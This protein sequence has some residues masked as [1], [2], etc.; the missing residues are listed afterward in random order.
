MKV[1]K[2]L[3]NGK[4]MNKGYWC[5]RKE[6][7]RVTNEIRV[8]LFRDGNDKIPYKCIITD[9]PIPDVVVF[10]DNIGYSLIDVMEMTNVFGLSVI[11][12]GL[13][14]YWCYI[15]SMTQTLHPD[16]K[17]KNYK[18]C[19]NY[20]ID[21]FVP[22]E[23]EFRC[24]NSFESSI[25]GRISY[26]DAKFFM[27]NGDYV[28]FEQDN[29]ANFTF[30]KTSVRYINGR[31]KCIDEEVSV[32]KLLLSDRLELDENGKCILV[33]SNPLDRDYLFIVEYTIEFG[34]AYES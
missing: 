34:D 33:L 31:V 22:D 6:G 11:E 27:L 8:H 26:R 30:F 14:E 28:V 12:S 4:S 19:V 18:N 21:I 20:H 15:D 9:T 25:I 29:T 13:E 3:V 5:F 17:M 7:K 16:C 2:L 32:V 10:I 1:T 24:F 23:T